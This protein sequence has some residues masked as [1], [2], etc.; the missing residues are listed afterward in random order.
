MFKCRFLLI[1]LIIL[2][3]SFIFSQTLQDLEKL[4]KA[5]EKR[6]NSNQNTEIENQAPVKNDI[7]DAQIIKYNALESNL[8][9]DTTGLNFLVMIF[10]QKEIQ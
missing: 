1:E 7:F 10:L 6:I 8:G 9:K 5:A 4:K 2:S 3:F